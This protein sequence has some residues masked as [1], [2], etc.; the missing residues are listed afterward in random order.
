MFLERF[1]FSGGGIFE[2]MVRFVVQHHFKS[3]ED[4][5][6]DLM[7]ERGGVLWTWSFW[8]VPGEE[9]EQECKKIRDHRLRYLDFEGEIGRGLGRVEIWDRG[10]YILRDCE[11]DRFYWVEFRGESLCG[12]YILSKLGGDRWFFRRVGILVE[13]RG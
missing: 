12:D 2:V 3:L 6:F 10:E 11:V 4:I 7:L 5:H 8:S 13:G 9:G 1:I